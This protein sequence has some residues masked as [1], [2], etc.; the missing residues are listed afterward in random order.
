MKLMV[1]K[2]LVVHLY[3]FPAFVT[4]CF[5]FKSARQQK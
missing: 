1:E 5:D 4:K 3:N 2:H